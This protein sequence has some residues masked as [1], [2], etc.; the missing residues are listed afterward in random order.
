MIRLE[1][2]HTTTY[3]YRNPVR[4]LEH[5]LMCRPRGSHELRLLET[6]MTIT[7]PAQV[8]WLHDVFGNSI[9]KLN[10]EQEADTLVV[11][12]SFRAEHY[13]GDPQQLV[14]ADYAATLP[15]E[16]P[17]DFAIDLAPLMRPHHP[18]PEGHIAAWAQTFVDAHGAETLAVLDAMVRHIKSEFSYQRRDAEG[19]WEPADTL[20]NRTGSCR[21]YALLMMEAVRHLG[22]AAR[23]VSG[24]LY[25]ENA[26]TEAGVLLGGG[27]THAW[28]DVYLPGEGWVAYDPTNALVAGRNLIP[29]A[30]SRAPEQASPL[31]GSF[32]GGVDDFL[33]M[34]VNVTITHL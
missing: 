18:D 22:L 27:E 1:V 32:D 7:P 23:F 17:E 33:G 11:E 3:R 16:Y 14:L 21:D 8:S 4:L 19:T 10:F 28:L 34:Q 26:A 15:F 30:I 5:R 24:Y 13:P 29:V 6:G 20:A 12:T 2:R 31:S 9:A 25:D